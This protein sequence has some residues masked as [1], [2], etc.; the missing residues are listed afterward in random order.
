MKH[1]RTFRPP[2]KSL[3]MPREGSINGAIHVGNNNSVIGGD[4]QKKTP[5]WLT[6][7]CF[8]YQAKFST[9]L[10]SASCVLPP[11]PAPLKH[12]CSCLPKEL[13]DYWPEKHLFIPHSIPAV[14]FCF[15]F[16][17]PD[18]S[19][20]S[21]STSGRLTKWFESVSDSVWIMRNY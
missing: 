14:V 6:L 2:R 17:I 3:D 4:A 5:Y 10:N 15:F 18:S 12:Y 16:I 9:H 13:T 19:V 21:F 20:G 7:G 8:F 11:A 1:F